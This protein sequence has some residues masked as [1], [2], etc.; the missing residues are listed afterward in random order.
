MLKPV[1]SDLGHQE[2]CVAPVGTKHENKLP[3]FAALFY[4]KE[5][6][7]ICGSKVMLVLGFKA[8]HQQWKD[9][10]KFASPQVLSQY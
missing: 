8:Q 9:G 4:I 1:F 5:A 10:K 3:R 7:Y 6:F 2:Q